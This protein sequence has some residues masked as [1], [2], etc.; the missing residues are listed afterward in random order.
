MA[1]P[2][3]STSSWQLTPRQQAQERSITS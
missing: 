1:L 3:T 2:M